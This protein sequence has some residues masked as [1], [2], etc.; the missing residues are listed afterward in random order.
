VRDRTTADP[1][2]LVC[3]MNGETGT[4]QAMVR[5]ISEDYRLPL[6]AV[7][8]GP[9]QFTT[10]IRLELWRM[11]WWEDPTATDIAAVSP[12]AA[13][14]V[15][16]DYTAGGDIVGDVPARL[17]YLTVLSSAAGDELGRIWAGMRSANKHGT[18]ANFEPI[19]EC[20][21]GTNG[22]DAADVVDATASAGDA[23]RVTPGTATWAER[24]ELLMVDTVTLLQEE[25]QYG[26][27]LWLLRAKVSAGTWEVQLRFGYG[28]MADADFVRGP[29][30]EV[31][32]T[33]WDI[34]ECGM[35]S[36][37]GRNLRIFATG[38]WVSGLDQHYAVQVWAR[39]TAGAGTVDFDCLLLM[40]V[41]E[42]FVF[43]NEF[44]CTWT[45]GSTYDTWLFGEAP[46]GETQA[47]TFLYDSDPADALLVIE[48]IPPLSTSGFRLPIG[49]GR[50]IIVYAR[51]ASTNI[52]DVITV[53]MQYTER[54]SSLRGAE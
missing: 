47:L 45:D 21:D 33:S 14:L 25:E 20:E 39:R 31:T 49:D 17:N 48:Y 54:W 53:D 8:D 32:N 4:R 46:T 38:G 37:P 18:L 2:W 11:P 3:K 43:S 34:H 1:V 35:A 10:M 6:Y 28:G 41:D 22:T 7:H 27:F 23:V 42:G 50:L 12:A 26:D 16:V 13:A 36:I 51:T 5:S 29:I 9:P 15:E 19:W 30:V 40:P 52:T 24:L 44:V